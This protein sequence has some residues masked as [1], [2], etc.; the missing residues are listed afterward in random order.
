MILKDNFF[1]IKKQNVTDEKAEFRVKLNAENFVYQ[2]HFPNN[3]I[4]PGVCL[5][6]M[7]VE[8]F[9]SL[10]GEKFNI[11]TLKNVKFTAPINPLEFPEVDFLIDFAKNKNLWQIKVLIKEKEIVFAK[12]SLVLSIQYS[13]AQNQKLNTQYCVIIPVY[14]S[15]KHIA[16]VLRSVL[17]HAESVIIVNDGSTDETLEVVL[18]SVRAKHNNR[19]QFVTYGKNRGKGYALQQGFRWALELGFTHAVTMDAD[20]QHLAT[21]IATLVQTSENQPNALIVGARKFDN[22]NMPQGNIFANNFSNF[23]FMVQTGKKLPDT[24]TGFRIYPLQKIGKMR[25]FTNRYEAELEMLVR[26]AWRNIPI[27]SQPINVYYP[28]INERLS[29]FRG[30]KDFFRISV[31]NTILCFVAVIYGYPSMFLRRIFRHK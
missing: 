21:D 5:I 19:V 20:G 1:T 3:P 15:E 4:T 8:L 31:L 12:M 29:H 16:N 24:Q 17:K 27:I 23:W 2:A 30:G 22:P 18:N 9:G 7:A 6:Q 10:K 25:L 28:P 26:S 11:K 13:V 14:N